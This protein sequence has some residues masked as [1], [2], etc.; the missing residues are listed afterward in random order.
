MVALSVHRRENGLQA[1]GTTEA[2]VDR[3]KDWTSVAVCAAFTAHNPA[4]E[5]RKLCAMW[6]KLLWVK[7]ASERNSH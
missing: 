3:W 7:V 6:M 4:E 1:D 5:I 2:S